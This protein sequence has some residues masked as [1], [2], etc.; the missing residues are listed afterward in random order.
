V[1]LPGGPL[2]LPAGVDALENGAGTRRAVDEGRAS[3]PLERG[4]WFV[5]RAGRRVGAV[6][7][8]A[9][10]EESA[11]ARWRAGELATRLAGREG[12]ASG[13]ADAWVRDSF[14]AGTRRPAITPLLAIA[15]LLMAAEAIAV[16]SSR[17]TA[18]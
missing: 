4:V 10:P 8:N 15:L 13:S 16:R 9:P 3:A 11:L 12:R 7:V 14:A 17:S 2:E 1:A 6:V 5:L 18:A